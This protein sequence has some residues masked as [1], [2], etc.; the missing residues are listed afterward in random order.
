MCP[1]TWKAQENRLY[2]E[3]STIPRMY[4]LLQSW[5]LHVNFDARND[6]LPFLGHCQKKQRGKN[7]RGMEN[8]P[9]LK[10]SFKGGTIQDLQPS[11]QAQAF[12]DRP[13]L[14]GR[15][16]Q[17]RSWGIFPIVVD[18]VLLDQPL[19]IFSSA[20]APGA[21][22][23]GLRRRGPARWRCGRVHCFPS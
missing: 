3:G 8:Y 12:F 10:S 11:R 17:R 5:L 23:R 21:P 13:D 9:G 2:L 15:M 4:C 14:T 6:L 1:T 19:I 16:S 20:L 18:A 7:R 22:I